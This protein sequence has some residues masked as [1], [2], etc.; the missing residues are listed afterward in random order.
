MLEGKY[1]KIEEKDIK[2]I[3][4]FLY[5][6]QYYWGNTPEDNL[7]YTIKASHSWI[8]D[9]NHLYISFNEKKYFFHKRLPS[10]SSKYVNIYLIMREYKLKRVLKCC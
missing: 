9:D 2:R 5:N 4:T 10:D 1:I 6:N 3:I 8:G 7:E